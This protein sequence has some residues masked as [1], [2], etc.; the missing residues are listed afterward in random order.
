MPKQK[1]LSGTATTIMPSGPSRVSALARKLMGSGKCS[2][3]C[4]MMSAWYV[5]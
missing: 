2:S 3:T 1:R 4:E 5:P